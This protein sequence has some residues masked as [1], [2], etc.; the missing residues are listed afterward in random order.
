[1]LGKFCQVL[2]SRWPSHAPSIFS[3]ERKK[4]RE[5]GQASFSIPKCRNVSFPG[6]KPGFLAKYFAFAHFWSVNTENKTRRIKRIVRDRGLVF[7]KWREYSYSDLR[8]R[9]PSET[10]RN[11]DGGRI[12]Y[13]VHTVIYI[14][15]TRLAIT[16][17]FTVQLR[18]N[19]QSK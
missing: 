14:Y 5:R 19:F 8:P 7:E 1:M 2:S 13:A 4:I 3:E 16:S 18:L 12:R 17:A 6:S 15:W 9:E 10:N 11:Q